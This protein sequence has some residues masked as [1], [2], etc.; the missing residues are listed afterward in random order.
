[1]GFFRWS[2][3]LWYRR[4]IYIWGFPVDDN[5]LI[6]G[7]GISRLANGKEYQLGFKV[8]L[9]KVR[10]DLKKLNQTRA[11]RAEM[12]CIHTMFENGK[13]SLQEKFKQTTLRCHAHSYSMAM[14]TTNRI[15][16]KT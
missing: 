3:V 2:T 9:G 1:M 7:R 15:A 6:N 10:Q 16:N 13:I 14:L 4:G 12:N 8:I 5:G 11:T